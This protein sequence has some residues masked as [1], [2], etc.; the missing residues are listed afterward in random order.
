MPFASFFKRATF[1]RRDA[2]PDPVDAL[3]AALVQKARDPKFY[4]D[5]A[6]PDTVDG[7]FDMIVIHAML[8][9]RRLR[10]NPD[11]VRTTGQ[12]LFDLM[13]LDMDRSLREMGVGDMSVGK[14][15]KKMAKAFYGRASAYEMGM[16]G[17][18]ELLPNVI[19]FNLYRHN[20]P[21]ADV[22]NRMASYLQRASAHLA[23]QPLAEI[24]AGKIDF[25]VPVQ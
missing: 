12:R 8:V 11:D 18:A 9:M 4:T 17:E 21:S 13:F 25:E 20:E 19:G 22:L 23:G 14:H 1:K 3:Y 16:D 6:V 10:E 24:A 5:L 2:T 15:V 7:R